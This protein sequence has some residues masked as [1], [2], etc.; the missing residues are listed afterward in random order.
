[1]VMRAIKKIYVH[2]TDSDDS[3]DIGF[4][5]VDEWHRQRGWL[6]D[7]GISCG[8][9]YIVRRDGRIEVGRP[10]QEVGSHVKG[11]NST[12]IGIVWV[13]RKHIGSEQLNQML[14]LIKRTMERHGIPVENVLG[15]YEVDSGKT[16]PNLGMDHI[17]AELLFTKVDQC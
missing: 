17:R 6:S 13:G 11:H 14:V 1:M 10:E 16:C 2:V 8:Y 3:L 9:H 12:S 5:E 15:H 4:R 7:S